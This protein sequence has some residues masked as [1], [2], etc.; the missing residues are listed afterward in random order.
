MMRVVFLKMLQ[1]VLKLG[2][3]ERFS[4]ALFLSKDHWAI[5]ARQSDVEINLQAKN[6]QLL[7]PSIPM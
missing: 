2:R 6:Q 5:H 1:L 3:S 7:R 4:T